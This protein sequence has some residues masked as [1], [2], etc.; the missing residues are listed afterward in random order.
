MTL[1]ACAPRAAAVRSPRAV[2]KTP[3][4]TAALVDSAQD[5]EP[6]PAVGAGLAERQ[7]ISSSGP[8]HAVI[9]DGSRDTCVRV[10]LWL[11]ARAT[12]RLRNAHGDT[13]TETHGTGALALP[14]SGPVC[15]R[16]GDTVTLVVDERTRVRGT[17]FVSP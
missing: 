11:G 12:A 10:A 9:T 7:R 16:K 8:T 14:P 1:E 13:L 2:N 5:D 3:E 15:V 6:L 4:A 17:V